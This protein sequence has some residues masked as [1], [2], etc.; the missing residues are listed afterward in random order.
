[1]AL[2][3]IEEILDDFRQGKMVLIMDDEDRENEGDLI[4][5]ADV[6]TPQ[7]IT[8]FAREACGLI[9]LTLTEERARQLALPLMVEH[10]NSLHE[11]NF[12][13]S[14]EAANGITTGISAADRAR[15]VRDAVA[16]NATPADIVMPGHI[17]PLIAK[18]GGVLTRAGHTE[19]G[20]DLARLT[21]Y[22]PAAVI[23]EVMN[24]DGSMAKRPQLEAFAE[25][26]GIRIGTI[27][28]LI[29]YRTLYDKTIELHDERAITTAMGDF[30][31]RTYTD[32]VSS[33]VHYALI[34]G[35]I[36]EA[37][38]C[39]VR[40]QVLNTLRDILLTQR[41]G[42]RPTWSLH[43]SMSAIAAEDKGVLVVVGQEPS[44]DESLTQVEYFPEVP[45]VQ[46]HNNEVGVY[47]VIGTGS[48]ILR[49]VGVGK[50]RL[51]SSP[52][53]FNAISGFQLEVVEFV[54]HE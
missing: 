54:E 12:T 2:N 43:D 26:H 48:Q 50:M 47:R 4:I 46:R 10:N 9:C 21:G 51:L 29:Q 39:L 19:A 13:V 38:P 23:V 17:F 32:K 33:C 28:D 36:N 31:L 42:F 15:T 34:R 45:P 1:M 3:S 16:R 20:C 6:V 5:A 22:E 37:E 44:L 53:R 14:I 8:F 27:A 49:D 30:T 25:Q 52:T 18:P 41:P 40:V 11:T 7:H 35:D 24:E